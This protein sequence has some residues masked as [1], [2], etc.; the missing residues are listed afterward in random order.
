MTRRGFVARLTAGLGALG[1]LFGVRTVR[2]NPI[3]VP[4]IA[5]S[6]NGFLWKF[7]RGEWRT[8]FRAAPCQNI[9]T[10]EEALKAELK[11]NPQPRVL[12]YTADEFREMGA[13]GLRQ[14]FGIDGE[15]VIRFINEV[16]PS[17]KDMLVR[18]WR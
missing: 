11:P 13:L 4:A 12:T 6:R 5:D 17:N 7:E 10:Y 16:L 14:E 9:G 15:D 18:E 8:W 1:T 2:A 3:P